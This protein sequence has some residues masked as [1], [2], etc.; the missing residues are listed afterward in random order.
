[1]VATNPPELRTLRSFIEQKK[2]EI[3]VSC[4]LNPGVDFTPALKECDA[5]LFALDTL[6]NFIRILQELKS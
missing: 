1:M 3:V 4:P 5:A 6:A 2:H